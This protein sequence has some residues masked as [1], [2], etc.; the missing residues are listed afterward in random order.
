MKKGL[1]VGQMDVKTA[2]LNNKLEGDVYIECPAGYDNP[3]GTVLK[4]ERS[5]YGLK[6]APKF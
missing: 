1:Y 5:L 2:F 6:I 4:L 3:E